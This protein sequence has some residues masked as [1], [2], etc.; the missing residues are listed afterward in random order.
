VS[1]RFLSGHIDR[2]CLGE[3]G[4]GKGCRE[5]RGEEAVEGLLGQGNIL[6]NR[7]AKNDY[8]LRFKVEE[9]R[10]DQM[11]SKANLI[12]NMKIGFGAMKEGHRDR[13]TTGVIVLTVKELTCCVDSEEMVE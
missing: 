9:K 8:L 7:V 6:R 5:E 4:I 13:K 10:K 11:E 2:R 12:S 3:D 1:G